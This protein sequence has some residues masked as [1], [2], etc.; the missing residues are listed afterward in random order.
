MSE[1]YQ[2]CF[3][4]ELP[5]SSLSEVQQITKL[6]LYG[7]SPNDDD[8]PVDLKGPLQHVFERCLESERLRWVMVRN[9]VAGDQSDYHC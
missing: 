4:E 5:D 9:G 3:G 2:R 8:H 7:G 6:E 1:Y